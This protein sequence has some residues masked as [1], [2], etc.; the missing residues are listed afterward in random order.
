M[1]EAQSCAACSATDVPLL[2]CAR[3][4][5]VSYCNKDCQ[6]A[7]WKT[8]KQSCAQGGSQPQPSTDKPLP[9]G[10]QDKK[11]FTA[12]SKNTFLHNRSH[13]QTFQL[14]IDMMR[15]RQA[16]EFKFDGKAMIGTIYNQEP[17]S[18]KAFGELIRKAEAVTGLLPPWWDVKSL[19]QCLEYSCKASGF[20]LRHAQEKHDI[21]KTW[22]D[23]RMPMKLRMVAERVYGYSP[24]G[25]KSDNLLPVLIGA[26]SGDRAYACMSHMEVN[27]NSQR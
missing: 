9:T 2:K 20:S 12:I 13:E 1:A 10:E 5:S 21:Q 25:A 4:K 26:E 27:F 23:D 8:H 22:G 14:L 18:E 16:D 7:H 11:P 17:S 19:G 24:G 15:M 3:C 6:K